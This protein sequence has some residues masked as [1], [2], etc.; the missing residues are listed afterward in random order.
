MNEVLK[1]IIPNERSQSH[2]ITY[3]TTSFILNVQNKTVH[4]DRKQ[5]HGFLG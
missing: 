1:N 2:K 3:Y 5:I 4:T